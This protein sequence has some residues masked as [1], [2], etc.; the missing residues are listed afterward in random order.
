MGKLLLCTQPGNKKSIWQVTTF[1]SIG[2]ELRT[3]KDIYRICEHQKFEARVGLIPICVPFLFDLDL[4]SS[5]AHQIPQT[6]RF[7]GVRESG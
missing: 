4:Q 2:P 5:A 6:Y 7:I 3:S 1:V